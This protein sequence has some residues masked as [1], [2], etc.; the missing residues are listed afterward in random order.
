MTLKEELLKRGVWLNDDS[1]ITKQSRLS[2]EPPI[3]LLNTQVS[4][5]NIGAFTNIRGG[6]VRTVK[7]IGRFTT[8]APGV[9]IGMGEH[10]IHYLSSHTFQYDKSFGFNFWDEAKRFKTKVNYKIPKENPVIGSDVWIG[11]NVTILK[12][13]TIGD[14]AVIAAGAVVTKDVE[15]YSIV[16]GVPAK[17]I[18]YRFD[19]DTIKRLLEIKWWNYMLDSLEGLDFS[20]IES[21]L[22][23]LENRKAKGLLTKRKRQL[24]K[25]KDREI[26]TEQVASSTQ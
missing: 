9:T 15:P 16:G 17:F 25:I 11:A 7:S 1:N 10:P 19:E 18:K 24:V 21:A 23:E 26:I 20:D 6:V 13:V 12:G 5:G 8:I 4:Y 22:L 3:R 14:G 2:I